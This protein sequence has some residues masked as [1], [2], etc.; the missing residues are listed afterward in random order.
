MDLKLKAGKIWGLIV[1]I[2][3]FCLRDVQAQESINNNTYESHAIHAFLLYCLP[4]LTAGDS[5]S[6]VAEMQ[7]LPELSRLPK[8]RS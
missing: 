2:F 4:A 3:I 8:L 5:V 6:R 7:K 1:F